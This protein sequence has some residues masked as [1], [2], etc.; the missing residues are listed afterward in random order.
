MKSTAPLALVALLAAAPVAAQ[1]PEELLP[2]TV[3]AILVQADELPSN[4][5]FAE[6]MP[7]TSPRA[8]SYYA[9]PDKALESLPEAARAGF[10]KATKKQC[11]SFAAEGGVPGSVFLFEYPE[12]KLE[13]VRRFIAAYVW[14]GRVRSAKHPD[15]LIVRGNLLWILSFPPGDPAAEWYK[16]RLRKKFRVP[17]LRAR[18]ELLPLGK[19]LVAA[20]SAR[21]AE[22]GI[23]IAEENEKE[24]HGWSFAQYLLGEFAVKKQDWPK[25]ERAYRRALELHETL[26][27]PLAEGLYWAA[28][29]GLGI[30]LLY[31]RKLDDAVTVLGMAKELSTRKGLRAGAKS[32][33]NLA[34]ACAL[35]KRWPEA[36]AALEDAIGGNPRYRDSAR[37]DEDLAEARERP[38]FQELLK[39][40]PE[41]K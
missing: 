24:L 16:A 14:E 27:D 33:Y 9:T 3:D 30:A 23:Q 17:A 10:P 4:I 26:E 35:Q 15:E 22:K 13:I 40:P 19:Q 36:L 38:E 12:S 21:D 1:E 20:L 25:A 37:T 7:S 39:A 5:K 41:T 2:L 32:A 6:G 28:L 18:P 31:Q 8:R 29:D 11:Q 34:C